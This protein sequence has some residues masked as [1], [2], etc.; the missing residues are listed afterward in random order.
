[1][2]DKFPGYFTPPIEAIKEEWNNSLFIF[3][4]NIL[5]NLYRLSP[6]T[7]EEILSTLENMN[8]QVWLPYH[9]CE[10]FFKNRISTI[11]EQYESYNSLVNH[12]DK[13]FTELKSKLESKRH[14]YLKNT[15][16]ILSKFEEN[17][18]EIKSQI[19]LEKERCVSP[20]DDWILNRI[21]TIYSDKI[22]NQLDDQKLEIIHKNGQKRYDKKI[23]PGYMDNKKETNKFGDYI[24]WEEILEKADI[25][26]KNIIF[27][28]DDD[29]EDWWLISKGKI[30]SPRPE[31]IKEFKNKSEKIFHM[32]NL[33][34]FL[35]Y[36][37][38]IKHRNLKSKTLEEIRNNNNEIKKKRQY[39]IRKQELEILRNEYLKQQDIIKSIGPSENAKLYQ[40]FIQNHQDEI[41]KYE[42]LLPASSELFNNKLLSKRYELELMELRDRHNLV[43][44]ENYCNRQYFRLVA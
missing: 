9:V 5:L 13:Y 4:T 3:D 42:N 39:Q 1:M 15:G 7:A 28:S 20:C 17:C 26:S 40:E 43:R 23:P 41:K 18:S 31:L 33:E 32:Y 6:E 34:N 27:I 38:E 22:G 16:P 12:I 37:N 36:S 25:V 30:L 44:S 19:R 11:N 21:E 8:G 35:R 2:R 29:K 14:P 10:E 24:I